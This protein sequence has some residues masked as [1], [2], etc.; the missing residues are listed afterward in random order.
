MPL[1]CPN[2]FNDNTIKEYITESGA[3]NRCSYCSSDRVHCVSPSTI[4]HLFEFFS[5]CIEKIDGDGKSYSSLIQEQFL[6]FNQ[7]VKSHDG[8]TGDVLGDD[9]K[10]EQFRL[11]HDP[12]RHVQLWDD[13]KNELKYKNRFFPKN[14]LYSSLFKGSELTDVIFSELLGQ[15]EKPLYSGQTFYRARIS[16]KKLSVDEMK[17]PPEGN[18]SGGRANPIGISYLYLANNEETCIA[19]VRPS[20]SSCIRISEFKL[21]R[22]L[23]ILDLT[24]PR[25]D[26]TVTSF[27]GDQVEDLLN[28]VNL[29]ETLSSELSK[30]ILPDKSNIDY[31]PTQFLCEFIKSVGRYDGIVFNSSFG[32]GLNYVFYS[33]DN[34]TVYEPELY[35]VTNTRHDY[36]KVNND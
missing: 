21:D 8:L 4:S 25:K 27:E 26:I 30:P 14:S 9:Y 7:N 12:S 19:E 15:L 17:M 5:Y 3:I 6:F 20:N 11:K 29:F 10:L 32:N 28:Y 22:D 16:D 13:F 33:Q 24:S 34:F 18:A 1:C 2:C 23:K 35:N 31:L 36:I